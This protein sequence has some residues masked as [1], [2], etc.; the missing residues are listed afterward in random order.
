MS[1]ELVGA[2]MLSKC[3]RQLL[4]LNFVL[5]VLYQ[6]P[7]T[8][9]FPLKSKSERIAPQKCKKINGWTID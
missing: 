4:G 1:G 8:I 2:E 6:C 7:V 9:D 5:Q 3:G